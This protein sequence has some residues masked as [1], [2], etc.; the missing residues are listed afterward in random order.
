VR[1]FFDFSLPSDT[2][3]LTDTEVSRAEMISDTYVVTLKAADSYYVLRPRT[4]PG[5]DMRITALIQPQG[6]AR[7]GLVVRFTATEQG[8]GSYYACWIDARSLCGCLVSISDQWETVYEP[9]EHPAIR[10][11]EPN[12]V[13]L[14]A[15]GTR[16]TLR[17][18]DTEITS[19]ENELVTEGVAGLYLEN[20]KTPTSAVFDT[21]EIVV[22]PLEP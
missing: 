16:I 5:K 2:W 10:P 3:V 1:T 17:V 15:E 20:F 7:A 21:I 19:F 8:V 6:D 4:I 11:G 9:V 22:R 12:R 13:E 18:N 14:R